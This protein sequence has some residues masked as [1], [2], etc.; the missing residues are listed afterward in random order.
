MNDQDELRLYFARIKPVYRE[1][2]GMA[3]AISG[4]YEQAEFALQ[5]AILEGF[6]SRRRFRS[7]R[8][9]RD[10][11]RSDM[12]KI[13]LSMSG[14]S[15]E[16]TW[17]AFSQSALNGPSADPMRRLVEQEDESMRRAI[18]LRYGCG[19]N[20]RQIARAMGITPGQADVMLTKFEKR[21]KRKLDSAQRAHLETRLADICREELAESPAVPDLGAVFRTFEAEAAGTIKPGRFV[22]KALTRALY[23]LALVLAALLIWLIAAVIRPTQLANDGLKTETLIDQP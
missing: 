22:S 2:F 9:F 12:R 18:M 7:A 5:R 17:T 4:N 8:G 19:M 13:C 21:V 15:R 11:L 10:S 23:V 3:H 6:T 16:A 1:L 14:K 20:A